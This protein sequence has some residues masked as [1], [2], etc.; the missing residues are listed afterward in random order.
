ML[1]TL[2]GAIAPAVSG[3]RA[4]S[5]SLGEL[6]LEPLD[7]LAP[8]PSASGAAVEPAR[9]I[10]CTPV[11]KGAT[12][13][14]GEPA[15]GAEAEGV[16]LPFSL[17]IGRAATLERGFAVGALGARARGT[18]AFVA[19]VGEDG[20]SGRT[21]DLGLTHGTFS[22]P[23]LV[24][25]GTDLFLLV[26]DSDA[27]G[28]VLRLGVVRAATQATQI[29]W[30]ASLSE[31]W[32]DSE[33]FDL[34]VGE[35]RGLV[36]WD[37]WDRARERSVVRLVDFDPADVSQVSQERA[38]EPSAESPRLALRPGGFWLA[39]LLRRSGPKQS[40]ASRRV[41]VDE[42][43]GTVVDFER[44]ALAVVPL[45]ARGVPLGKPIQVGTESSQVTVFDLAPLP[46]G[47]VLTALRSDATDPG[48]EG[49]SVELSRI[50]LD[51][52]VTR[53]RLAGD[54]VDSGAPTL[55]ADPRAP[56]GAAAVWLSLAGVGDDG[57]LVALGPD[58]R[59]RDALAP[60]VALGRG[61]LLARRGD[62]LL[63]AHPRGRTVAVSVLRCAPG[64]LPAPIGSTPGAPSAP[65]ERP[66]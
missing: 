43:L 59:P 64:A 23:E 62:R 4:C 30:G 54:E 42:G 41:E 17:E 27:A 65:G 24:A 46:D 34:A 50:A 32:D 52:S 20:A 18:A 2:L 58:G 44:R 5:P 57:A 10:R 22:P 66:E 40:E 36:A 25:R 31:G 19:I 26:P 28:N 55:L 11:T 60:E 47:S 12:F 45:D 8:V 48:V 3:C 37:R 15:S 53:Y 49:G 39:V 61:E 21:L 7:E 56:N 51:G 29:T 13:L 6:E 63:V 9:P 33:V 38:F 14:L 35:E 16:D 1:L